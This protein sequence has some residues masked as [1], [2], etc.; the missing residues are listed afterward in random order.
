MI[1][2]VCA[3]VV[4]E[5]I[6]ALGEERDLYLGRPGVIRVSLEVL[7]DCL[8][9]LFIQSHVFNPPNRAIPPACL[10]DQQVVLYH[11]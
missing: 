1:V 8:F 5:S 4:D 11:T 10:L 2:L 9:F 7:Y 6:D 3:Q